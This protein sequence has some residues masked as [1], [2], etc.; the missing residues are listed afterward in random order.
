MG[1]LVEL[2]GNSLRMREAFVCSSAPAIGWGV[3]LVHLGHVCVCS[4][5]YC[6]NVQCVRVKC[7]KV[8]RVSVHQPVVSKYSCVT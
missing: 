6:G 1:V 7:V 8:H 3:G 5:S 4:G 2:S